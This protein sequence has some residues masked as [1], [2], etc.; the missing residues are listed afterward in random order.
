MFTD[1]EYYSPGVKAFIPPPRLINKFKCY[2]KKGLH[3]LNERWQN[4]VEI[5]YF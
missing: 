3:V 5:I 2:T 1:V 4:V